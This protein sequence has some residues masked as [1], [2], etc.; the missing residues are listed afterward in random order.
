MGIKRGTSTQVHRKI[1]YG[2]SEWL[3]QISSGDRGP[4]S[5]PI[6]SQGDNKFKL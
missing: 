6:P 3:D 4:S 1:I 2:S 5:Q